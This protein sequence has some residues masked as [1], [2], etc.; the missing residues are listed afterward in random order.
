MSILQLV[1]QCSPLTWSSATLSTPVEAS[2]TPRSGRLWLDPV[3]LLEVTHAPQLG[4][5]ALATAQRLCPPRLPSRGRAGRPQV[6]TDLSVFLTSLVAAAWHLSYEDVTAALAYDERLAHALGYPS[7]PRRS[8]SPAQYSRRVR[9]LGLVPYLL[10]F[11]ALVGTLVRLGVIHGWDVIIDSS[12]LD[13]WY[14]HDPDADWNAAT[15]SRRAQRFG[16]KIHSVICRWS[17]LPLLFVITPANVADSVIAIPLLA[18]AV[19][20][21]GLRVLIVRADAGYFTY[22]FLGFIHAVLHASPVVDYNLRR[23]GRRFLATLFFLRQWRE[24]RRPRSTIE[25]HFAF[26]KR[27]FGLADFQVKGWV[28]VYRYALAVHIALL[29]VA[30]AATQL[31]RPDLTISRSRVLAFVTD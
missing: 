20:L 7:T 6:Y 14:K 16:Y 3:R 10:L 22:A 4:Q 30:L 27:Y 8:I 19:L 5:W 9:A 11:V 2:A 13:A 24:A 29:L 18:G 23:R 26:L 15:T 28:A 1:A 12:Y 21:Y 25:R 31:G 17:Y